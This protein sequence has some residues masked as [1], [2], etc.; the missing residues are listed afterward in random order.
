MKSHKILFAFLLLV[1]GIAFGNAAALRSY[2]Y[3]IDDNYDTRETVLSEQEDIFATVSLANLSSGVHFF[4]IRFANSDFEVSSPSRYLFYIPD[5]SVTGHTLTGYEYWLDDDF[6]SRT[7]ISGPDMDQTFMVDLK[8]VA[9]GI[10][11]LNYRAFSDNSIVGCPSRYLFYIPDKDI[12]CKNLTGYEY[13]LDNDFESRTFVAGSGEDQTMLVDL[14]DIP[15]GVHFFNYR[16]FADN[17]VIASPTRYLFYIPDNVAST[18]CGIVGYEYSFNDK[19]TF[20]PI[21]EC[22]EFEM[23][24]T[25]ILLP[26]VKEVAQVNSDCTFSFADDKATMSNNAQVCFLL[27]FRNSGGESSMPISYE[28]NEEYS[29]SKECMNLQLQKTVLFDKVPSGDMQPV[30]FEI[31][32][33]AVYYIRATQACD[34][35]IFDANGKPKTTVTASSLLKTYSVSLTAGTYYG[36]VHNTLSDADNTD[37]QVGLRLMATNN[38][39]PTPEISYENETVTITCLQDDAVI[40]YTLDG[41]VPDENSHRYTIPFKLDHNADIRAVAKAPDYADSYIASLKVDSYKV[42]APSIQFANLKI[43]IT[44]ETPGSR[45]YYTIDGSDPA[46]NGQLY[47]DAV[48]MVTSCTVRAVAKKDYYNDSDVAQY[49]LDISN[50]KCSVPT[51]TVSGNLLTMSTLTAGASIYYTTD[52]SVPTNKCKLYRSPIL[53]ERNDRY[54]AVAVKSGEIDSDVAEITIDWF[55]AE[56]PEFSFA[57]G[58]LTMT[59]KTRGGTIYYEIGG[60]DPTRNSAKYTSPVALTDNRIVKAFTVAD[61]FNDSEI[62]SYSPSSFTCVMPQIQYD[63]RAMTLATSTPNAAIYYTI[64]GS[65]P[66]IGSERYDSKVILPVSA[67]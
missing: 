12:V 49:V 21:A 30:K 19:T 2:E 3:W 57:G 18:N 66:G 17:D 39:V 9:P 4:N 53:L 5:V 11:F 59:S 45:I 52:G 20:V 42:A 10:H 16:A 48:P 63:G 61:G 28:Y 38:A 41:T 24:A 15:S 37:K 58:K 13:W 67:R 56:I 23:N 7:H 22:E 32:K 44:C 31:P 8:D 65:N 47:N 36:I 64:D 55:N 50:V 35:F 62:V 6:N 43:Y 60:A 54:R 29:I 46:R 34:M 14:K 25:P 40:Y 27:R 33:S 51:L 26:D 1:I